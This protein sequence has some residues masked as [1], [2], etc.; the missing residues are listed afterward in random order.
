MVEEVHDGG[1]RLNLDTTTQQAA[2][3]W[4]PQ[5]R[6]SAACAPSLTDRPGQGSQPRA[7]GEGHQQARSCRRDAREHGWTR[8][9]GQKRGPPHF[10]SIHRRNREQ[11][12][13]TK[14]KKGK[15]APPVGCIAPPRP[16]LAEIGASCKLRGFVTHLAG[17]RLVGDQPAALAAGSATGE[18]ARPAT[19]AAG[20]SE[21]GADRH[22]TEMLAAAAAAA[23][24]VPT[25]PQHNP[26]FTHPYPH[27][28]STTHTHR[29]PRTVSR[30][31]QRWIVPFF[32]PPFRS[33]AC[34]RRVLGGL[35]SRSV[36]S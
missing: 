4:V 25:Q 26:C 33:R 12:T 11:N 28:T 19:H 5:A 14:E 32:W 2:N 34:R 21:Q 29:S 31:E 13:H 9:R 6:L 23:A 24:A 30:G 27:P 35:A 17:G 15:R 3:P 18:E 20:E 1:D 8:R 10:P 36:V 22:P 7:E 16:T